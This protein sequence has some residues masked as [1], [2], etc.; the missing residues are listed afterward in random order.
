MTFAY[1][2]VPQNYVTDVGPPMSAQWANT[3]DLI[4]NEAFITPF[5]NPA[6]G[7]YDPNGVLDSTTALNNMFSTANTN[8][9]GAPNGN[10]YFLVPGCPLISN[11]IALSGYDIVVQFG[12]RTLCSQTFPTGTYAYKNTAF[13]SKLH[14]ISIDCGISGNGAGTTGIANGIWDAGG[15]NQYLSPRLTH[16]NTYGIALISGSSGDTTVLNPDVEQWHNGDTQ[17]LTQAYHTGMG[18]Y[19]NRAD[20]YI[21]GGTSRWSYAPLRLG[22]NA[23]DTLIQDIH[24]YN[25]GSGLFTPLDPLCVLLDNGSTGSCFNN[26][27]FDNGH[28]ACYSTGYS[29]RNCLFLQSAANCNFSVDANGWPNCMQ[30]YCN[31]QSHPYQSDIDTNTAWLDTNNLPNNANATQPLGILPSPT[32]TATT[33]VTQLTG[34]VTI[35]VSSWNGPQP[36]VSSNIL[37][38]GVTPNGVNGTQVVTA[39]TANSVSFAN[40][41]NGPQT[42]AGTIQCVWVPNYVAASGIFTPQ[43]AQSLKVCDSRVQI[44]TRTD[45]E[46]PEEQHVKGVGSIAYAYTIANG[47]QQTI[48]WAQNHVGF[49]GP[50]VMNGVSATP[51]VAAGWGAATGAAIENNFAGGAATLN[52][53]SAALAEVINVLLSYGIILP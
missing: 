14:D 3:V 33:S 27:E 5:T 28:V 37:V 32:T 48:T 47:T 20:C 7:V 42:V 25:G 11:Q 49:S 17:F 29:I 21:R 30:L 46:V 1:P 9:F 34:T 13:R 10:S 44:W 24:L 15:S 40:A 23:I 50:V 38:A 22:P 51:F 16:F 12:G 43:N 2:Y 39:V 52:Q 53:T 35:G 26:C 31:G 18:I 6:F 36:L 41:T 4:V 8:A 19:V 45:D